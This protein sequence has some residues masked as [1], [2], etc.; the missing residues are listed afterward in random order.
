MQ[1]VPATEKIVKRMEDIL[2]GAANL[3]Q[4]YRKQN[5]LARRLNTGNKDKFVSC[6]KSIETCYQDLITHL[7]LPRQMRRLAIF[8]KDLPIDELDA[9][10]AKFLKLHGGFDAVKVTSI[11]NLVPWVGLGSTDNL[12]D[13]RETRP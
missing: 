2:K 13:D 5:A 12:A 8:S 1:V 6:A 11:K 7:D 10:S 4:T 3:I 9:K